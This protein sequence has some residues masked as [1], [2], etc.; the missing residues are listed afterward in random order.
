M[1]AP[2]KLRLSI[3]GLDDALGGDRGDEDLFGGQADDLGPVTTAG[4][5]L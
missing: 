1:I 4:H 5:E 2:D 3:D